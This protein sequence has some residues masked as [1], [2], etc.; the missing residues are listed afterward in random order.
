MKRI[1]T[2]LLI[3]ALAL[4]GLIGCQK[5]PAG[6]V[7]VKVYLLGGDKGI[8]SEELPVGRYWIGINE[9]L[10]LF[11]TFSQNA[12]WTLEETSESPTDQSFSFQTVEGM[13]VSADIGITYNIEPTKVT[14]IFEKYR[15]G[16]DEITSI[17]LR[18]M[19]RDALVK[20]TST[21]AIESV[22]GAGKATIIESVEKMVRDQVKPLGINVE[23]I[24]WIGNLRLPL[25][26]TTAI[27]A[28]ITATQKTQQRQNE[29]AQSA[30]EANKEIEKAR[31]IAESIKLVSIAEAQ[32]I[33]RKG[34]AI[35][36]NPG[37]VELNAIDKWDGKLPV[38][39]GGSAPIPFIDVK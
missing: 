4:T 24:Y 22:Y 2:I 32:A 38:Y 3:A 15:K 9:D 31:G 1:S 27:D 35:K 11:P 25:Q 37:V 8:S 14:S 28:K 29:V 12:V 34:A 17:Y 26:V 21:E 6:H 39:T 18:N 20:V 36:N 13:G 23:R 19:V 7:G 30:A 10:Y 5:V 16:V 33:E